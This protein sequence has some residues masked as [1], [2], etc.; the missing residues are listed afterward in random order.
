PLAQEPEETPAVFRLASGETFAATSFG[1]P[2]TQPVAGEVVFTTSLVGYPESMT[3]PSYRGQ[4]LVFTQPLV[5]NYGVPGAARDASGLLAHFESERVQ[6]QAVI[7][8]DYARKYS[9]WRAVESLGAWCARHGVPALTGVDTR[10]VV[11]LLREGGSTS[12]CVAP[13]RSDDVVA[14]AVEADAAMAVAGDPNAR[15]LTAEVCVTRP[16][17]YRATPGSV[18]PGTKPLHVAVLDCGAKN[19]ILRCVLDRGC[20]VTVLPSVAGS[21]WDAQVISGAIGQVDGLLLSNGPGD[22]RSNLHAVAALKRVMSVRPTLPIFGIC[23]GHQLMGLAAGA[24]VYKMTYGNRGHNQPVL[25]LDANGQSGLCYVTSQNHGFALDDA[26]F[27]GGWMPWF[28]NANDQSNE[29][30]RHRARPWRSVQFHPEAKGGPE[31]TD[32]LFEAFVAD[33]RAYAAS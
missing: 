19:N 29:G 3:D 8:S 33:V 25:C 21:D 9:H 6:P 13:V 22:P 1:A 30:L 28:R 18:A 31:D 4:I 16:V 10:A 32:W 24:D 15:C 2:L 27:T 23:M 5:G 7:V 26:S 11:H 20:D 14:A 12:G 17:R